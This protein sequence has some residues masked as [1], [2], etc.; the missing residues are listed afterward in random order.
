MSSYFIDPIKIKAQL[1]IDLDYNDEDEYLLML[2]D[3]AVKAVENHIDCPI[4]RFVDDDGELEAPLL[5]A[6]LLMIGTLYQNRESVSFTQGYK[7]PHAY[8]YLLQ[9]YIQYD[10]R[11]PEELS[12]DESGSV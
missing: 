12:E 6:C 5:H 8:E 1:N 9:P 3:V 10:H 11:K 4:D 7:V 2:G